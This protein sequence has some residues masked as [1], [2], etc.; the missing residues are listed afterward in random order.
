MTILYLSGI[1][2]VI[3]YG[4]LKHVHHTTKVLNELKLNKLHSLSFQ[5]GGYSLDILFIRHCLEII[6]KFAITLKNHNAKT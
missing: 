2:Q 6:N 4:S 3:A 1:Y 5:N